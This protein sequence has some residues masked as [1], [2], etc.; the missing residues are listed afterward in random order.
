[1]AL[2]APYCNSEQKWLGRERGLVFNFQK[3]PF[4]QGYITYKA[5]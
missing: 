3:N 1:M 5:A 2:E 4:F